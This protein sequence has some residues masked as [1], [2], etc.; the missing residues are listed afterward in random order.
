MG[1][2]RCLAVVC[3]EPSIARFLARRLRCG[4]SPSVRC[5]SLFGHVS[6]GNGNRAAGSGVRACLYGAAL[7]A[8]RRSLAPPFLCPRS[9]LPPPRSRSPPFL[10]P[11][12]SRSLSLVVPPRLPFRSLR[13]PPFLAVFLCVFP[14]LFC[15]CIHVSFFLLK[16][17][18]ML[19]F[20]GVWHNICNI[21]ICVDIDARYN[22]RNHE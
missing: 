9:S 21:S 6:T 14:W 5:R 7:A 16:K 18:A 1:S 11:L 13:S 8:S 2:L 15:V 19:S 10:C 17:A 4:P 12:C 3:C 22:K 20:M